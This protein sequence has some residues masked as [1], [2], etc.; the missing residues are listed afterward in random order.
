MTWAEQ[1][2]LAEGLA[3]ALEPKPAPISVRDLR[4]Q[5]NGPLIH[6]IEECPSPGGWWEA[7]VGLDADEEMEADWQPAEK[8]AEMEYRAAAE[9]EAE[10]AKRGLQK[11]YLEHLSKV[12]GTWGLAY[13]G[14]DYFRW[15]L[16]TASP[17]QRLRAALEAVGVKP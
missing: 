3:H 16:V 9:V 11:P 4:K 14:W 8:L 12:Q 1:V 17:E 13:T 7:N 15:L 6:D 5:W 2:T 10:I